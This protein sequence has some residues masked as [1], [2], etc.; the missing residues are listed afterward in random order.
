MSFEEK[1]NEWMQEMI[2]HAGTGNVNHRRLELLEKGLGHGTIEFLRCIWFPAI[3]NF[4]HLYPEWEVRDFNNG[5]RYLDLAY[6]PGGVKGGIEIQG[7]G[8][9]ARDLDVKRF[10]DLCMRHSLLTLDGWTFMPIA[11]LSI[12]EDPKQCQQL[13]LSFVGR[14]LS[15]DVSASLDWAEA[16]VVRFARRLLRPITP[17]EIAE[18][19][20][21]SDRHARRVLHQLVEKQLLT[22]VG[23]R[24]RYRTFQL[25]L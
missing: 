15:A 22:V 19:L 4:N 25:K 14:F 1:Y 17:I 10:K 20:R 5:Y 2:A 8:S 12:K 6:M 13:I 21:L 11:Y 7:F 24:Q 3:G 9:H 16:E 23:G 18:H